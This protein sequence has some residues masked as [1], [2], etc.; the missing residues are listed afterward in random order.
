MTK[1]DNSDSLGEVLDTTTIFG[2]VQ[3]LTFSISLNYFEN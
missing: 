1:P 2:R 3:S